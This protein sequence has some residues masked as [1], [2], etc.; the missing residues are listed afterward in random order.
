MHNFSLCK[1]TVFAVSIVLLCAIASAAQQKVTETST[2]CQLCPTIVVETSSLGGKLL[3]F[4]TVVNGISKDVKLSYSWSVT[5]GELVRG[6]GSTVIAVRPRLGVTATVKVGGL[7]LAC[8][9]TAISQ[10]TWTPPPTAELVERY[11]RLPFDVSEA[12]AGTQTSTAAKDEDDWPPLQYLKSDYKS[13]STVAHVMI[14]EAEITGRIGGYE[15][16]R[17]V[18]EVIEPFKGT[19]KKG[20]TIEYFHGAEAGFKKEYFTGEKIVFLLREY[21]KAKKSYRYTV[22]ENSTLP[23]AA[24]TLKKLRIIKPSSARSRAGGKG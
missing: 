12:L 11:S 4:K 17:I 2:V 7:D 8:S 3:E 6:Q 19:F 16:W 1:I 13:V 21:D 20:D 10:Y 15:N 23:A 14:R 9:S 5:N 24:E 22:L 18:C